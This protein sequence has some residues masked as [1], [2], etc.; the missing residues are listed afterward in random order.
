M[1]ASAFTTRPCGSVREPGV[2]FDEPFAVG[3]ATPSKLQQLCSTT[4]TEGNGEGID[5]QPSVTD[6]VASVSTSNRI[7]IGDN[8]DDGENWKESS[9]YSSNLI[10]EIIH[11]LAGSGSGT[12]TLSLAAR[13]GDVELLAFRFP[14]TEERI[15]VCLTARIGRCLFVDIDSMSRASGSSSREAF[16]ELLEYAEERLGVGDV[17]VV[18]NRKESC[19]NGDLVRSFRFLGF[20]TLPPDAIFGSSSNIVS[21]IRQHNTTMQRAQPIMMRYQLD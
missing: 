9:K 2:V 3:L 14:L 1:D 4:R 16:C 13:R 7:V 20:T 18:F 15:G 12:T 21:P 19:D 10:G 5:E 17:V 6:Y 11:R 8:F